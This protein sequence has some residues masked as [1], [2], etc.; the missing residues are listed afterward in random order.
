MSSQMKGEKAPLTCGQVIW[1]R[2]YFTGAAIKHTG[3]IIKRNKL[4]YCL[5][6]TAVFVLV[7]VVALVQSLLNN[8]RCIWHVICG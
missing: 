6:F 3:Q 1:R 7:F 2:L 4:N 8:V 5:G